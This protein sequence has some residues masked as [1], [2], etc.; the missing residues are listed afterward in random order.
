MDQCRAVH[1]QVT[2]GCNGK[3]D[4]VILKTAVERGGRVDTKLGSKFI[5]TVRVTHRTYNIHKHN[6]AM[7]MKHE[8]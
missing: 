7:N 2:L 6:M 3:N 1:Y 4:F 8:T 5:E